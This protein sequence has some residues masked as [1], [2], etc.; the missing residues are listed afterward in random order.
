MPSLS[1]TFVLT[2]P[3]GETQPA[4]TDLLL[5]ETGL[6]IGTTRGRGNIATWSL[7]GSELAQVGQAALAGSPTAGGQPGLAIVNGD[8]LTGGGTGGQMPLWDLSAGGKIGS[9]VSLGSAMVFDGPLGGLTTLPGQDGGTLAFGTIAGAKRLA[10]MQFDSTG[11]LL[12]ARD[13]P[14]PPLA[15]VTGTMVDGTRYLYGAYGSDPDRGLTDPGIRGWQSAHN[16]NLMTLDGLTAADN[17]WVSAPTALATAQAGGRDF[18]VLASAGS[19]SLTVMEI[20]TGGALGIVDHLLDDRGTRF[21]G[22]TALDETRTAAP[23]GGQLTGK[24]NADFLIGGAGDDR[25]D[26]GAGADIIHDGAGRDV[27]TGGPGADT[28]VLAYDRTPDT[29][30][31]FE[32]GI[33]RLDLSDW[34]RLRSM[35]Q[36]FHEERA[37]GIQL[38]YGDEVLILQSAHGGPIAFSDLIADHVIP[39]T[40]L[41]ELP[42]AGF[43]G[44][45]V[46]P[47]LPERP[48]FPDPREII[49]TPEN[50]ILRG[51]EGSDIIWGQAGDDMIYGEDGNDVLLGGYGRDTRWA[52]IPSESTADRLYGGSGNDHLFGQSG[53]DILDGG[54]GDDILT[55]GGGYDVFI[56]H[57]GRDRITDFAPTVD[58]LRLDD[59]L[60]SGQL[61]AAQVV[62]RHAKVTGGD[63]VFDFGGGDTLTLE[64][65]GS[66]GG[67][68]MSLDFI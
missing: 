4:L 22:A 54:A 46:T 43:P 12:R 13:Y 31:D 38:T 51:H 1:A 7:A 68:D 28:F 19:S 65:V 3:D 42:P 59:A 20:G 53:P 61:T 55:G 47:D 23:S 30:T 66:L 37:D 67:L 63:V 56:F 41:P 58:R 10:V 48:I 60:W 44:P 17:L 64:D 35:A 33:D 49:G 25:I 8:L 29:I 36:F 57:E 18:L 34:P 45:V 14:A 52:G 39:G 6:L 27:L 62:D 32:V 40:R 9:P 24:P 11:D 2:P 21:A 16:G 50:D 26:G 15:A 5:D